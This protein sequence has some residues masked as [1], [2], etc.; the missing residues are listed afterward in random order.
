[1]TTPMD[2][3]KIA[4]S[5]DEREKAMPWVEKYRPQK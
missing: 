3:D 2:I 1:M 4:S 5:N